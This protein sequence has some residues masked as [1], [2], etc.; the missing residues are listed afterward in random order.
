MPARSSAAGIE[1][2]GRGQMEAARALGL[3]PWRAMRLVVLPPAF[4]R[5]WP[6]LASQ[7]VL[8]MLASSITSQISVEELTGIAGRVQSETFRSFEVYAVVGGLYLAMAFALRAA[9]ALLGRAVF[10]WPA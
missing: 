9:L 8:L 4:R 2:A 3:G 7:I 1:G 6:A 10:R 5:I